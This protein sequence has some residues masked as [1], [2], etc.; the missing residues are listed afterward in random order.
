MSIQGWIDA[1]AFL[2]ALLAFGLLRAP[3]IAATP[4]ETLV[5]VIASARAAIAGPLLALALGLFLRLEP[6]SAFGLPGALV[7]LAALLAVF[8]YAAVLA[9]GPRR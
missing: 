1:S 4:A 8:L 3:A 5:A 6:R 7:L 2:L 9:F